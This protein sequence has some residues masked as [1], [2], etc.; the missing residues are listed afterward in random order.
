MEPGVVLSRLILS[1]RHTT[2]GICL[3]PTSDNPFLCLN[4]V[5]RHRA[6]DSNPLGNIEDCAEGC[7]STV[8][9][10]MRRLAETLRSLDDE[11]R[12]VQEDELMSLAESMMNRKRNQIIKKGSCLCERVRDGHKCKGDGKDEGDRFCGL[13]RVESDDQLPGPATDSCVMDDEEAK[14]ECPVIKVTSPDCVEAV[15]EQ[16]RE[17]VTAEDCS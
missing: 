13:V 15:I 8:R 11:K 9:Q 5:I 17:G 6:S 14:E 10:Q 1:P 3:D 4:L 12:K 16:G 7:Q 2:I